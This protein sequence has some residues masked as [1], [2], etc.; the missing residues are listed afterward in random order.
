MTNVA[1]L[2]KKK[3][4]ICLIIF[5]LFYGVME[6]VADYQYRA[7]LMT[8]QS[9][10]QLK[11]GWNRYM[12]PCRYGCGISHSENYLKDYT[13]DTLPTVHLEG[14]QFFW[15]NGERV[16][17]YGPPRRKY[18]SPSPSAAAK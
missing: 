15:F 14:Y 2:L 12:A 17:D 16:L 13:T 18:P 7:F 8:T 5:A 6:K 9:G 10:N 4:V 1:K 3:I 11:P